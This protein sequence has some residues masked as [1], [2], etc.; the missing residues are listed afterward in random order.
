MDDYYG[1]DYAVCRS[2]ILWYGISLL[3]QPVFQIDPG[4][5][6]HGAV[7]FHWQK[8]AGKFLAVAGYDFSCVL[9]VLKLQCASLIME[10]LT[11]VSL[12]IDCGVLF[13]STCTLVM[14]L[15]F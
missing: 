1:L 13:L 9:V 7:T 8:S 11:R 2:I 15:H 10:V 6:G 4:I 5:T 12:L 3:L 14:K